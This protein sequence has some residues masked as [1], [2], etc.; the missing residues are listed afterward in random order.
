MRPRKD[1][2]ND[3]RQWGAFAHLLIEV[4]LDIR[5]ALARD[6]RRKPDG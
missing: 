5:D 3:V 2:L 4:L 1:I 6:N